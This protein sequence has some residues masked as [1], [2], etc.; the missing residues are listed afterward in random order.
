MGFLRCR[1]GAALLRCIVMS[2]PLMFSCS[3][4]SQLCQSYF[5]LPPVFNRGVVAFSICLV[6]LCFLFST[7]LLNLCVHFSSIFFLCV[8]VC[9][10]TSC[11]TMLRLLLLFLW[12]H[13]YCGCDSNNTN[14]CSPSWKLNRYTFSG[15][16]WIG[17]IWKGKLSPSDLA[18]S[19][20]KSTVLTTQAKLLPPS[21][22][23]HVS[24]KKEKIK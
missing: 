8:Y 5:S 13:Y 12:R 17:W 15:A 24:P 3:R 14:N 22:E 6:L 21:T 2:S 16:L 1:P 7:L 11:L 20:H 9:V 10:C 19:E 23:K 18:K 4:S